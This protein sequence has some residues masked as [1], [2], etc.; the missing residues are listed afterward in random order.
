MFLTDTELAEILPDLEIKTEGRRTFDAASQIQ[1]CSIDL[2]LDQ[3]F[4]VP[5]VPFHRASIDLLN[6]RSGEADMLRMFRRRWFHAGDR[7]RLGP[8]EMVFGRTYEKF[9]IPNGFVAILKGRSTYARLGLSIHCTG[10]FINPGWRGRMPLQLVN[11]GVVPILIPPFTQICQLV[12]SRMAGQ[13]ERPYGAEGLKSKYQDDDGSP[14]K[15]WMEASLEKV[16]AAYERSPPSRRSRE[17]FEAL[18][19]GQDPGLIDR[20]AAYLARMPASDFDSGRQTLERFARS[21]EWRTWW[22]RRAIR[23]GRWL[24][25]ALAASSLG[26][27]AKEPYS[28]LHW[29]IWGL[30]AIFLPVA[31]WAVVFAEEPAPAFSRSDVDAYFEG[32]E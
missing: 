22:V 9:T 19:A 23:A 20:F 24:P 5:R 14:S 28:N 32:K 11:H 26:L 4:W 6:V 17:A 31:I 3:C 27:L 13:S 25:P 7:I 1:P 21:E 12:V 8:G 16:R 2:R 10:D 18:I 29:T 15:Y 30:T